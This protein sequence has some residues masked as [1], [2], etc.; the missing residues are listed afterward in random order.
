MSKSI[1]E[2]LIHKHKYG[3]KYVM[4]LESGTKLHNS[5]ASSFHFLTTLMLLFQGLRKKVISPRLGIFGYLRGIL[6]Q[7]VLSNFSYQEWKSY[8]K[9][10]TKF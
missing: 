2:G 8:S 6:L 3:S 5:S 1:I 10:E 7:I 9:R 4:E